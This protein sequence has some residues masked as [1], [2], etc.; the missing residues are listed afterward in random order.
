MNL[1]YHLCCLCGFLFDDFSVKVQILSKQFSQLRFSSLR[2][3]RSGFLRSV[4]FV[5]AGFRHIR[6]RCFYSFAVF[7]AMIFPSGFLLKWFSVMAV[8]IWVYIA[9]STFVGE[10]LTFSC[11]LIS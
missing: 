8:L 9:H 4:F 11:I 6:Y 7:V 1:I 2:F 5:V 10:Y 3:C